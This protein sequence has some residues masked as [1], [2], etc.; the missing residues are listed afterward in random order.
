[1]FW[2]VTFVLLAYFTRDINTT[3]YGSFLLFVLAIPTYGFLTI[4]YATK[5]KVILHDNEEEIR[6]GKLPQN[7][8]VRYVTKNDLWVVGTLVILFPVGMFIA[9]SYLGINSETSGKYLK[10]AI[11]III[12]IEII[13]KR[14]KK[15]DK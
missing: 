11:P 14:L 15:S 9:E 13:I 3:K 8:K 4:K 2:G 6:S 7:S 1:M 12:L 5:L 10:F